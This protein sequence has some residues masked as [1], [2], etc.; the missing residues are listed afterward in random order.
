MI[1]EIKNEL[2]AE[3]KKKQNLFVH[4]VINDLTRELIEKH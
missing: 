2:T 4:S 1:N 3:I